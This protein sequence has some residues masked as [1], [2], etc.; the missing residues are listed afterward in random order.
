MNFLIGHNLGAGIYKYFQNSWDCLYVDVNPRDKEMLRLG[1]GRVDTLDV[2]YKD[3]LESSG[4]SAS[5]CCSFRGTFAP[6]TTSV[7]PQRPP[8]P[9]RILEGPQLGP[10][11]SVEVRGGPR[12]SAE[13]RG[14]P[15]RSAEVS[16]GLW[17]SVVVLGATEARE[18]PKKVLKKKH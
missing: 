6:S 7:G 18:S 14:G 16:G 5:F 17:S 13:V 2:T 3:S 15:W 4:G 8:L 1:I 11:R 10:Q 12:R 9:P